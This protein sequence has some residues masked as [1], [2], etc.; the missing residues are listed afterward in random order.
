MAREIKFIISVDL[1]DGTSTIDDASFMER[2]SSAEQVWYTD[3]KEWRQYE[4]GEYQLALEIL[5]TKP[6]END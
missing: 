1:D 6:L 3:L 5:N 4:E 2:Y